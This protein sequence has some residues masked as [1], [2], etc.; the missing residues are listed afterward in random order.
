MSGEYEGEA[1]RWANAEIFQIVESNVKAHIPEGCVLLDDTYNMAL[2]IVLSGGDGVTFTPSVSEQGIISWTNDGGLPNP[3]PRN[4][5]GPRGEQGPQGEVGPQGPRGQMGLRGQIGPKGDKGDKGDTGATPVL[6]V[7]ASVDEN[8]GNPMVVV[9]SFGP[10]E[11][12]TFDFQFKNLKGQKGETGATGPQGPQGQQGE[13]GNYTKPASG[14]PLSDLNGN[15]ASGI[16]YDVT[17]NNSGATFAS[18]SALL[19]SG[20]LSTLIPTDVRKGGMQIR[21]VCSS[22]NRY[23]QYM[24]NGTSTA[25]PDFTNVSNWEKLNLEDEVNQLSEEVDNQEIEVDALADYT[26]VRRFYVNAIGSGWTF[27]TLST[28]I[29][30][31]T[32]IMGA[33]INGNLYSG[34]IFFKDSNGNQVNVPQAQLPYTTA[35]ELDTVTVGQSGDMAVLCE[36]HSGGEIDTRLLKI[37]GFLPNSKNCIIADGIGQSKPNF[38]QSNNRVYLDL[39]QHPCLFIGKNNYDLYSLVGDSDLYRKIEIYNASSSLIKLIFNT[40]TYAFRC[41]PYYSANVGDND[42]I[43][44]SLKLNASGDTILSYSCQFDYL[45]NGKRPGDIGKNVKNFGFVGGTAGAKPNFF[46]NDVGTYLD[47]GGDPVFFIGENYY[48]LSSLIGDSDLYRKIRI[49]NASSS[50]IK[51]IFN[52]GNYSFRCEPYYRVLED[53]DIIIA[54]FRMDSSGKNIIGYD[55]PFEYTIDGLSPDSIIPAGFIEYDGEPIRLKVKYKE[56]EEFTLTGLTDGVAQETGSQ[57]MNIYDD[58]YMFLGFA[59][60]GSG[61]NFKPAKIMVIDLLSRSVLGTFTINA[62]E[63]CHV[64]SVNIGEK[65]DNSDTFPLIYVTDCSLSYGGSC[66]VLRFANDLSTM[67]EVQKITYGGSSYFQPEGQANVRILEWFIDGNYIYAHGSKT[68][69]TYEDGDDDF[70]KFALPDPTDG[71]VT[72]LDTDII[73]HF[74]IAF[75]NVGQQFSVFA[76]RLFVL[77]GYGDN[78]FPAEIRVYDL[79]THTM[80]SRVNLGNSTFE[81]E[82][83]GVWGNRLL[84]DNGAYNPHFYS[85]LFE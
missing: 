38:T 77:L 8:V 70:C 56:T 82:G 11:H 79:Y 3:E 18:L 53:G 28:P 67:T 19:S 63:P 6:D 44:A 4:I 75:R 62:T 12:R 39:G 48:T 83:M 1:W 69:K 13:P 25:V 49:Y 51:L 60:A 16:V 80:L 35:V 15:V 42:V 64:N 46:I 37:E 45:I 76:G 27:V 66:R 71:D 26:G 78:R 24:Y 17:A 74:E 34:S 31:G 47:F 43:I 30:A 54:S 84:I 14:I 21:F 33:Y 72:L 10:A 52:T 5:R 61:D 65:Y 50:A 73:E 7:T 85:F 58:R 32:I 23:V 22:D 20:S 68:G 40:S 29:A 55:C 9:E 41:E 57:G 59:S 36:A 2:K 81:P